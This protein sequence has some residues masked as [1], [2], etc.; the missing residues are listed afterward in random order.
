V[1]SGIVVAIAAS[2]SALIVGA[3]TVTQALVSQRQ[4]LRHDR[5]VRELQVLRDALDEAL[6]SAR[7]RY[8]ITR[9]LRRRRSF[10]EP[11]IKE[12]AETQPLVPVARAKLLVR[13]GRAHPVAESYNVVRRELNALVDLII[14]TLGEGESAESRE[15]QCDVQ[16]EQVRRALDDFTDKAAKLAEI[17]PAI[18]MVRWGSVLGRV[19]RDQ[20]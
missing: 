16:A 10:G 12:L 20:T 9:D 17:D 18:L 2:A 7:Q 5:E 4:Q 3:A 14:E 1:D 11:A 13:L 15:A 19:E 6:T 8:G